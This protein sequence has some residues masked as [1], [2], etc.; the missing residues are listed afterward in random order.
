MAVLGVRSGEVGDGGEGV[1]AE[2]DAYLDGCSV[3]RRA[4]LGAVRR[5]FDDPV[6]DQIQGGGGDGLLDFSVFAG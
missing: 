6:A 3:L 2:A 4:L 5:M 1:V